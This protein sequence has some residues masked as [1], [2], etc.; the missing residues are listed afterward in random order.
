MNTKNLDP[1]TEEGYRNAVELLAETRQTLNSDFAQKLTSMLG[2]DTNSV[3]DAMYT[4]VNEIH[5]EAVEKEKD[6][7]P[8]EGYGYE[9]VTEDTQRSK[10]KCSCDKCRCAADTA[11]RA[12][13]DFVDEYI[14]DVLIEEYKSVTGTRPTRET[15]RDARKVL[16][17]Y[18]KWLFDNY[19][20]L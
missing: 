2:V 12:I 16:T 15:V 6:K 17:V 10:D 1:R 8:T 19:L 7:A 13:D 3:L 4:K 5:N 11:E 14:Y 9:K 18:T 20:D